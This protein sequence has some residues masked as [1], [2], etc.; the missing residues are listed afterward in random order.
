MNNA[1]RIVLLLT[2]LIL[3]SCSTADQET[4]IL[5]NEAISTV[6]LLKTEQ[7]Y[8]SKEEP[9]A[10]VDEATRE[11]T[12]QVEVEADNPEAGYSAAVS[13][14]HPVGVALELEGFGFVCE[15]MGVVDERFV[16]RCD[17]ATEDYQ[18]TVTIWGTTEDT[19]DLVEAAAYYYSTVYDYSDLTAVLFGQIAGLPNASGSQEQARAWV[20]GNVQL[21]QANGDEAATMIGDIRYYL[22]ALPASQVLEIGSLHNQ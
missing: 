11:A 4:E 18:Y 17:Q 19:V 1:Y 9:P 21:V 2:F 13:G 3:C 15:S 20:E 14:L 6:F 16:W 8:P 10:P 7:V 12:K 5:D 22:F